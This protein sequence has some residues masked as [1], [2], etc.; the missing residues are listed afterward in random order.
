[1]DVSA[2]PSDGKN[3]PSPEA[4][5]NKILVKGKVSDAK[6]GSSGTLRSEAAAGNDDDSDDD[7]E[8]ASKQPGVRTRRVQ[9]TFAATPAGD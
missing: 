4:L 9:R 7:D 1:L 6:E 2:V 8:P 5:K 3:L